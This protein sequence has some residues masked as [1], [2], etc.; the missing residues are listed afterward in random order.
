[1][2]FKK[3]NFWC[4]DT[5]FRRNDLNLSG[6]FLKTIFSKDRIGAI[7]IFWL[8]EHPSEGVF[9]NDVFEIVH[10]GVAVSAPVGSEH[11]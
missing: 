6:D 5:F 7:S 1:M 9:V 11:D 8:F 4:G 2:N 3:L 10:H